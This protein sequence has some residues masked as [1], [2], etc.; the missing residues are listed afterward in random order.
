MEDI[1][2]HYRP[3]GEV[4]FS[5]VTKW[6]S[7]QYDT[8]AVE[9]PYYVKGAVDAVLEKYPK[10]IPLSF[11]FA[12]LFIFAI[13]RCNTVCNDQGAIIDLSSQKRRIFEEAAI[14]MGERSLRVIALAYGSNLGALTLV[15]LV[16]I[17]DPPREEVKQA[18]AEVQ[19]SGVLVTMITGDSKETAVAIAKELNLFDRESVA[20]SYK[21]KKKERKRK[22]RKITK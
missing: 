18:I 14:E 8:G 10:K 12:L 5:P 6:M 22:K 21:V 2:R 11:P 13:F 19:R 7:I 20:L 15:G 1:R 3:L 4:P 9:P 16:G 17:V